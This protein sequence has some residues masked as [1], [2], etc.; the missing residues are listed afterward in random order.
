[1]LGVAL[2]DTGR[3]AEALARLSSAHD[4]HPS[5]TDIL[6]ALA[7]YSRRAGLADDTRRYTDR[8]AQVDPGHPALAELRAA[9]VG[10]N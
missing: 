9:V 8:L 2:N 7:L 1:V 4:R 10:G 6:Y 3:S 5:D